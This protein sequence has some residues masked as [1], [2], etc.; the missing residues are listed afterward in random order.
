MSSTLAFHLVLR[1]GEGWKNH[2][3]GDRKPL[4]VLLFEETHL[5]AD[6]ADC[7]PL[8]IVGSCQYNAD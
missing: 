6:H 8:W 1:V 5:F 4:P 3:A 7:Y 2:A